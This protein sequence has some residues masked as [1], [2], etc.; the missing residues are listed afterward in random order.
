LG[1]FVI[2]ELDFDSKLPISSAALTALG[3]VLDF[4]L[5]T[6]TEAL[7][8]LEEGVVAI[9]AVFPFGFGAIHFPERSGHR[10]EVLI[11]HLLLHFV[12]IE[13]P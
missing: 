9:G 8:L 1:F 10:C 4:D 5:Y 6:V 2:S 11:L 13:S 7:E 12:V 3:V